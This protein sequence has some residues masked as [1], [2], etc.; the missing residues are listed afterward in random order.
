M[1]GMT[2]VEEEY[3]AF[4]NTVFAKDQGTLVKERRE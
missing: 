2:S 3:V 1:F 4:T